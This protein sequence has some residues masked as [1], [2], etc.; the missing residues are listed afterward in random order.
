MT[1]E[2]DEKQTKEF[3]EKHKKCKHNLLAPWFSYIFTPNAIGY[4]TEI[5]CNACE[6]IEDVTNYDNW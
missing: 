3:I 6:E 4:H 2:I 1:F 5:R